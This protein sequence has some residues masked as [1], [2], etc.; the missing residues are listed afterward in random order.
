MSKTTGGSC[1]CGD[2]TFQIEGDFQHFFLCHCGHC[3]KDTGSAHAANLFSTTARL[4]WLS[5]RDKVRTYR[6]PDT[7][8]LKSFCCRCGS[9]LPNTQM[10]GQLLV[11]PA[12][13]LDDEVTIRPNAHIFCASKASWDSELEDIPRLPGSPA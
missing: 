2:V 12:G 1:L 9:A 11:V 13:S 6:L 4:S 5:G 10:N 8:H 3:Q 7:R